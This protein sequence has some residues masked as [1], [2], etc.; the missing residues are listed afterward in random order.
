ME[1]R[2]RPTTIYLSV[3]VEG[4]LVLT[5]RDCRTSCQRAAVTSSP[6]SSLAEDLHL[7]ISQVF[8]RSQKASVG[9]ARGAL[10]PLKRSV[11]FWASKVYLEERDEAQRTEMRSLRSL[12]KS[13]RDYSNVERIEGRLESTKH[14]RRCRVI[15][16]AQL[17]VCM[18]FHRHLIQKHIGF[19]RW[20]CGRLRRRSAT[21]PLWRLEA[22]HKK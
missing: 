2:S 5:W 11:D 10:G 14:E 4:L 6:T 19:P 17:A 1:Q 22:M 3:D 12:R 9:V 20:N 13:S 16:R 15:G 7:S 8:D 18:N 21:R